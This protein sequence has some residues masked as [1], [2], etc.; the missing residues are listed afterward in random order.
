M[1]SVIHEKQAKVMLED[2]VQ[3]PSEDKIGEEN[4]EGIFRSKGLMLDEIAMKKLKKC[5]KSG[6]VP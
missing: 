6:L 2:P 1:L 5:F 4:K 3:Y